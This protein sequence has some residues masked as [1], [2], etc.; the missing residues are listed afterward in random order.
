MNSLYYGD[1]LE[2][3][4]DRDHFPDES[5]DLIYLDPPFN[6]DEDHNLI[7]RDHSGENNTAQYNAFVDTWT[8]THESELTLD[9]LT[10]RNGQLSQL[11]HFLATTLRKNDLAAYLVSMAERL[12]ELHRVLSD[13]GTLYLHCDPT[14]SHYLKLILDEIFGP[15]RFINEIV[16]KRSSNRS[17]ISRINRRAHDIIFMYSKTDEYTFNMQYRPLSAA[18]E[19]QYKKVDEGDERAYQAVPLLVSGRRNGETGQ[20]WRGIDPNAR[21]KNGMHWVT[22]PAKLEEYDRQGLVYWPQKPGGIPRLKYYREQS[23]GVPMNDLWDDIK[24]L[25]SNGGGES[26]GYPTQKPVALLNRIIQ[27]SSNPG[28]VVLDPFCGC[29]T[30]VAAAQGLG[31]EWRGIDIT[32]L[33]VTLMV[34]RLKRDF[35]LEPVRDYQVEGTP[36]DLASAQYLFER[37]PFQFQFWVVGL[38]G[39]Q[40]YGADAKNKK[41]KKGGDTGIDGQLFFRT[42]GG[43]RLEKVI[44]SVKGGRN[45]NPAMVR[46][47][48]GTVQREGAAMGVFI[49]MGNV[50]K[51][52]RDEASKGGVYKYGEVALPRIQLLTV[53]DLLDGRRPQIP[54]GAQNVSY[55]RNE[56]KTLRQQVARKAAIGTQTLF[57]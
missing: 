40:P 45:L 33:S 26:L 2:V 5:V 46:D 29:G 55:E 18:S 56:V 51:G 11:M 14:A 41:G 42:P 37:N 54:H 22:T 21:G 38:A 53:Q 17:S 49:T 30:A 8:W 10:M 9:R 24:P 31:R 43:E 19:E 44:V 39:A 12:L 13:T 57:D 32:H 28:D 20:V 16:W 3:L 48:V 50:T 6:S 34:A 23:E 35:N 1:N 4:S 27:T 25:P 47:L 7:F 52:M 15:E 36:R